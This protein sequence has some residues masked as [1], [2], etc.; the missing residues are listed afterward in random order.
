MATPNSKAPVGEGGRFASMKKKLAAK[1]GVKN[2]SALAAYIGAAKYGEKR[3]HEMAAAG[4]RRKK[5]LP[6]RTSGLGS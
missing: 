2:P 3:M 1:P 6:K 5:P 4:K